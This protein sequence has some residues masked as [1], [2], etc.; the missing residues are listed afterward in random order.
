MLHVQPFA[1]KRGLRGARF[2]PPLG[3]YGQSLICRPKPPNGVDPWLYFCSSHRAG[4]SEL[5]QE[6]AFDLQ[7]TSGEGGRKFRS[8][9]VVDGTCELHGA[10]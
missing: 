2:I 9:P 3:V 7:T 6:F 5:R 10:V 1:W 4:V 8:Q